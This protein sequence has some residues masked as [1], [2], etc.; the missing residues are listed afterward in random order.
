LRQGID[1]ALLERERK[2]NERITAQLDDLAKLLK[3][4]FT[5]K[6]KS[7]AERELDALKS[8][9]GQVRA[10]I[11][12]RNSRYESLTA[13][14]PLSIKEIQQVLDDNTVLLEYE[15]GKKRSYLWAVTPDRVLS[16]QL[17]AKETIEAQARHVYRVAHGTTAR[18]QIDSWSTARARSCSGRAVQ[19]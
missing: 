3:G 8:E 15:L 16:Y 6:Q 1:V 4:R 2:I 19:D 9:L 17:P 12:A 5:S 7:A 14:Q 18:P 11:G 10:Q 13:P